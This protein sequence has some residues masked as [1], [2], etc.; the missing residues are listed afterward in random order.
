MLA[1]VESKVDLRLK[2]V[3]TLEFTY[4]GSINPSAKVTL[5]FLLV[6]LKI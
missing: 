2:H 6:T 3:T 1:E 4:H 5:T